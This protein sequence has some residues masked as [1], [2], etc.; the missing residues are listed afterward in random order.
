MQKGT[1]RYSRPIV[2]IAILGIILGVAVMIISTSIVRG[3]RT[4][5]RE[6]VVGFDA[7][8]Q[9][10]DYMSGEATDNIR[11]LR[12][13]DFVDSLRKAPG[14]ASVQA[15]TTRP[16]ILENKEGIEGVIARGQAPGR[17]EFID[18]HIKEGRAIGFGT[19]TENEILV[20]AI[21]ARTLDIVL[22]DKIS[23]YF[24]T[25]AENY[26]TRRLNVVGIYQ[27]DLEEFDR[28][29]VYLDERHLQKV[30]GWGLE[31]QL[32]ISDSCSADGYLIAP[33]GY[34]GNQDHYFAW[35]D[36]HT[37][38]GPYYICPTNGESLSVVLTDSYET[39]PDTAT[40]YF[41]PSLQS[42]CACPYLVD[43]V[44]TSGG[45]AKYYVGGFEIYI[46]DFDQ[47]QEMRA[48]I[49]PI[50]GNQFM[51]KDIIQRTPEIFSWLE[52]LDV[53][54]YIII[55][56]M[57]GVAIFNMSSALLIMIIE[58]SSMIGVLK[59]MGAQD[60]SVRKIF[61]RHAAI[62]I[63]KGLFWGN[64][65]GLGLALAQKHLQLIKLQADTYYLDQVPILIHWRDLLLIDFGTL[66]ICL[67]AMVIP[68]YFITRI[69]PVKAIRFD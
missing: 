3:F 4:E 22:G 6:K 25:D 50:I 34:G 14:I 53:N 44:M 45:S 68:S 21:T 51:V 59:A 36:G 38:K 56:L 16:S 32:L 67:L 57:I 27:T 37:G 11:V 39:L 65:L 20:S 60:W 29:F 66:V 55:T 33:R 54:I 9:V 15:F 42:D 41:K 64:I 47:L 46:D 5:I 7:H 31:A 24:I 62:L 69:S 61:I 43:T 28:Q 52:I 58:R 35:S 23:L 13:A 12:D 48:E 17:S 30:S 63:L 2:S 26:A 1:G 8:Y 18:A 40:V 49:R 10:K 19:K